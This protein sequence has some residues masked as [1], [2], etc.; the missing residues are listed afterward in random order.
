[1]K[2]IASL[3]GGLSDLIPISRAVAETYG[4]V[5]SNLASRGSL[6]P[7]N[8]MWIAATAVSNEMILVAHDEHFTR[9]DHLLLEDWFEP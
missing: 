9:V 6:I 7:A 5:R 1:L 8:D 3:L 2:E 4:Q